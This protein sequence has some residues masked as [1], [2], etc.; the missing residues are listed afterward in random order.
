[1]V[2]I[3]K[4]FPSHQFSM[5]FRKMK[6]GHIECLPAPTPMF[7]ELTG[8]ALAGVSVGAVLQYPIEYLG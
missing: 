3:V 5:M 2:L 1:M 4:M 6:R 8:V 7:S